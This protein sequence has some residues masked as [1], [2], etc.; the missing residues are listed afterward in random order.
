MGPVSALAVLLG[1][2]TGLGLTLVLLG[3]RGTEATK[4]AA[5]LTRDQLHRHALR[6]ALSVGAAVLIGA[7]TGWPVAALL[8][9]AATWGA[10]ALLAEPRAQAA[11]TAKVEA[12]AGWAEMLRD[13]MAGAAGLE[14]AIIASAAVAPLPLRPQVVALA[15][16]LERD[17]LAPSLRAFADEL[18]DPSADLVVAALLLAAEHQA[19]RLG[20]VLGTLAASAR[21]AATMR[22]RVEA[23]RARTRASV[24]VIV[25]V[26]S[27][28]AVLLAVLDHGYLAPYGSPV[29]QLM[30]ALVGCLFAAAF[31][32]M[33]RLT[34]P[35]PLARLLASAT[36]AVP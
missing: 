31:V 13:T 19:A 27:A 18:S 11:G 28:L 29:G 5:R 17:R 36:E 1:A 33:A 4:P 3:L 10:P 14:Q 30:L 26:T 9:G 32:W 8:A 25:G 22:L 20:E 2:G 16:A 6:L 15:A 12:V 7:V 24:K 21:D 23:A 35:A 34:R